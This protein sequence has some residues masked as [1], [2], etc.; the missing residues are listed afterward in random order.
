MK[1]EIRCLKCNNFM[2]DVAV[3]WIEKAEVFQ[4]RASDELT[5]SD[6]E[7]QARPDFYKCKPIVHDTEPQVCPNSFECK[8][9]LKLRDDFDR[10][11]NTS[12]YS[13]RENG[14]PL[15][16]TKH[17]QTKIKEWEKRVREYEEKGERAQA[18]YWRRYIQEAQQYPV[19]LGTRFYI[20]PDEHVELVCKCGS[21]QFC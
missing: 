8:P 4:A 10:D 2:G 3:R 19:I 15:A 14:K 16:Q 18:F 11:P 21:R 5:D 12:V 17:G 20:R 9:L 13:Q 7:P 1:H 6:D